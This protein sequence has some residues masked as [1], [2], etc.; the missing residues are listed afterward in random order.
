MLVCGYKDVKTGKFV[1]SPKLLEG[2][3]VFGDMA[4]RKTV[5]K[6]FGKGIWQNG[7]KTLIFA[8]QKMAA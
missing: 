5:R 3:T 7:A 4:C 8:I 2:I 1:Q 6:I